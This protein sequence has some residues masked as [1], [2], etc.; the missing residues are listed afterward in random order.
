MRIFVN[1]ITICVL[2]AYSAGLGS[3][4]ERHPQW[5]SAIKPKGVSANTLT[6]AVHGTT[7]YRI[8]LPATPNT[9]EIKAADDLAMWLGEM[10]GARFNIT[11][12]SSS[13]TP[14]GKEISVGNTLL[15]A[16]ADTGIDV[17]KLKLD[18]YGIAVK[19]NTLFIAG[20]SRR[21]IINGVYCLLE[22]DLNCR[23]YA[24]NTTSIPHV[25]T[26]RFNPVQRSYN[27][28]LETMRDIYYCDALQ[29]DYSIRNKT[30]ALYGYVPDEWGGFLS[31]PFPHVHTYFKWVPPEIYFNDHPEYYSLNKGVRV[32]KQLCI[33]NPD[34]QRIIMTGV[35]NYLKENPVTRIIDVSPYD[36]WDY[37]EC[38]ECTKAVQA[39]GSQMGPLM[40]VVND[41][42][43]MVK[44]EF[45]GV[46]VST[47]AY[48]D[49]VIPPKYIRPKA[50]VVI[51]LCTDAHS[52]HRLNYV[53]ETKVTANAIKAWG[54][55]G[56][57][58]IIWDYPVEFNFLEPN[59]N[60][61]VLA[62]NIRFYVN[63]GASG[64]F[65]Q[66]ADDD[67]T[68]ADHSYA[69]S[70]ISS[71]LLWD[72][73]L[74]TRKLLKDFNYGFYGKAAPQMQKY[75]QLLWDSWLDYRK[76]MK[77]KDYPGPRIWGILPMSWSLM[78]EAQKITSD[79][80]EL[81]RRIRV[82]QLPVLYKLGC[83]GPGTDMKTY[84]A[85]IDYFQNTA[86]EMKFHLVDAFGVRDID[87]LCA[88]WRRNAQLDLSR[89]GVS[90]L[91]TVWKCKTDPGNIGK[92]DNWYK[93]NLDVSSW[94][95]V[96]IDLNKGWEEQ[97]FPDFDGFGWYRTSF[98]VTGDILKQPGLKMFFGA[99]DEEAEIWI[100]G[101]KA[102]DHTVSSTGRSVE[103][104]WD[105]PFL[106][107]PVPF[108]NEGD[109]TIAVRVHDQGQMGGIWR[110]VYL[111]WGELV[112]DTR[113]LFGL[114]QR[115][116]TE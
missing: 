73:S 49:T 4:V 57:R 113:E 17:R 93:P 27:P 29:T 10:T 109:N 116:S 114:I 63:N 82:A 56:A 26:L 25:P 28:K 85:R 34:V 30:F 106:I 69:R 3:S 52:P 51:W 84:L 65:L 101:R 71:K 88:S 80:P 96:R 103:A 12:E 83:M 50:N 23:W 95:D 78:E 16:K 99:V 13:F 20:G 33:T 81:V 105:E 102:A 11:R 6:L 77:K 115:K 44:D 64:V 100:N 108:L 94:K 47:L 42:A 86:K 32:A 66:S 70:W 79:D 98:K 21:G 31:L 55:L 22:E 75:D 90:V 74:D 9:K 112:S 62:D 43:D 18:G 8:V 36:G 110:P 35:R 107:D 68:A 19:G 46:L 54:K 58:S 87:T 61:P 45:P 104:L 91:P 37:C 76:N 67:N 59:I 14:T 92:D 48:K 60:L 39:E 41:V 97:G 7:A 38:P 24:I 1:F 89:L 72:Q 111:V 53:Y 2:C 5:R 15:F 40:K